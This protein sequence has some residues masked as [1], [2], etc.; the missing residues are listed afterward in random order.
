MKGYF[1]L[2][3]DAYPSCVF[4]NFNVMSSHLRQNNMKKL[5]SPQISSIRCTLAQAY[6]LSS[7]VFLPVAK[8]SNARDRGTY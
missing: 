4:F 5:D 6:K 1:H 7:R 8:S 3:Q 2:E